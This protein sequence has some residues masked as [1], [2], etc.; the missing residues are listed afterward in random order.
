ML[1]IPKDDGRPPVNA[2]P[3]SESDCSVERLPSC[4]GK[5]PER[6]LKL[7]FI[8][9]RHVKFPNSFGIWPTNLFE[10]RDSTS[11]AGKVDNC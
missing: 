3:L 1:S 4:D 6:R 11:M 8:P 10:L 9:C 5:L 7:K 2:L